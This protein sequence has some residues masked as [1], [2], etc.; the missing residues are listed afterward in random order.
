MILA[1][2]EKLYDCGAKCVKTLSIVRISPIY[3]ME[4][5]LFGCTRNSL[6]LMKK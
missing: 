2:A 4:G 5:K 3:I 1:F 6:V